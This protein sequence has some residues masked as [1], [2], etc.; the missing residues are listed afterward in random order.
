MAVICIRM[1]IVFTREAVTKIAYAHRDSMVGFAFGMLRDWSAAEDIVHEAILVI[2]D[3]WERYRSEEAIA[4][5]LRGIVRKKCLKAMSTRSREQPS[6]SETLDFLLQQRL[7]ESWGEDLRRHELARRIDA[8]RECL[9]Q[10]PLRSQRLIN[11]FYTQK[12]PGELLARHP[13]IPQNT[14]W[15]QVHRLR[16]RLESCMRDRLSD[17]GFG[18][19]V[20]LDDLLDDPAIVD[21]MDDYFIGGLD[22]ES[23]VLLKHF[24]RTHPFAGVTAREYVMDWVATA[25]ASTQVLGIRESIGGAAQP[26]LPGSFAIAHPTDTTV[27]FALPSGG[28]TVEAP[29]PVVARAPHL[30]GAE[31]G[32]AFAELHG[33]PRREEDRRPARLSIPG[34][35]WRAAALFFL[36]ASVAAALFGALSRPAPP[37]ASLDATAG[38]T[39]IYPAGSSDAVVVRA[40][41][42]HAVHPGD[43]IVLAAD[44]EAQLVYLAESTTV[45]LLPTANL[46]LEKRGW[47]GTDQ[48][49]LSLQAGAL[50]AEVAPQPPGAPMEIVTPLAR[51]TVVGTAFTLACDH[52]W[53]QLDVDHGEV[54]IASL[55]GNASTSVVTGHSAALVRRA[56]GETTLR[57]WIYS[58]Q[59]ED[60]EWAGSPDEP[61]DIG[62]KTNHAGFTGS[63]YIDFEDGHLEWTVVVPVTGRYTAAIRYSLATTP[64]GL[65]PRRPLEIRVNGEVVAPA[66]PFAPTGGWNRWQESTIVL[67]LQAGRNTIRLGSTGSR[68]PGLD[69]L[70]LRPDPSLLTH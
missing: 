65:D 63:G 6:E 51:T 47:F 56:T 52:R 37:V 68:C 38:W 66:H 10:L 34:S 55:D 67:D 23:V 24:L 53:S 46:Q 1:S 22:Q 54:A 13:E 9:G 28:G 31:P 30:H 39:R 16:R 18:S 26:P 70:S 50:S 41:D 7:S 33:L 21:V 36:F 2:Y 27:T 17:R 11:D 44:A 60:A 43:R 5:W 3:R 64:E 59:A 32:D 15:S 20:A 42:R 4:P 49:R 57:E 12:K 14:L 8:L 45:S 62:I 40:G 25:I 19:D 58:Y 48:K 29:D 35:A 69:S 61:T